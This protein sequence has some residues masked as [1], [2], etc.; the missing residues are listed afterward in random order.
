VNNKPEDVNGIFMWANGDLYMGSFI[1]GMKHGKG[2][3]ESGNDYYEGT[4]KLNR[5]EGAGKI[6]TSAS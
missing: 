2:R 3:W 1:N 6:Q 4:W 5:P